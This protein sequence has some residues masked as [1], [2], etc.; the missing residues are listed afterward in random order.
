M[1]L[2]AAVRA[3]APTLFTI[4]A[5]TPTATPEGMLAVARPTITPST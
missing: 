2:I 1:V 4:I 5:R 3:V